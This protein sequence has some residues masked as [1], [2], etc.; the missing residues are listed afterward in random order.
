MTSAP[1]PSPSTF[2]FPP[3]AGPAL[4]L[5]ALAALVTRLAPVA[6]PFV[7]GWLLSLALYPVFRT[8][9][10]WHVPSVLSASLVLAGFLSVLALVLNT[11]LPA[12]L[13]ECTLLSARLPQLVAT[14]T[15]SFSGSAALGPLARM[16]D[17]ADPATLVVKYASS[18]LDGT[19]HILSRLLSSG[20][21][22]AGSVFT[23]LMALF[24]SF[25]FMTDRERMQASVAGII[26]PRWKPGLAVFSRDIHQ[27]LGQ[28]VKGQAAVCVVS[29]LGHGMG[30]W[31]AGLGGFALTGVL[32][33]FLAFVP[34]GALCLVMPPAML[35]IFLQS[36]QPH[37][38]LVIL[39]VFMTMHLL[40]VNVLVPRLIGR[41]MGIH[42]LWILFVFLASA[43]LFGFW[44][45]L[46][47]LPLAACLK[48]VCRQILARY[49]SSAWFAGG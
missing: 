3:W 4:L 19:S 1:K 16:L 39:A 40:E 49:R 30:L 17:S 22:L 41:E 32:A 33:G 27:T 44:G 6:A 15:P 34:W 8:L 28:F 12:L 38:V 43:D 29:M 45:L 36:G 37:D 11:A 23:L 26:P 20:Q 2:F 47:A 13:S 31:L 10:Q 46:L 25:Y 7:L 24:S 18:L 48:V 9:R 14:L 5:A 35:A 42:P 21:V